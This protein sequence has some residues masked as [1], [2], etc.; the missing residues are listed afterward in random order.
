[1]GAEYFSHSYA[2]ARRHFLDA[3][4]N[5]GGSIRSH[6]VDA[7]ADEDLFID[8][9]TLGPESAPTLLLSSG[10]HGVEGFFGSAVQLALLERLAA[11]GARAG[12]RYV[13]VHAVNPYGFAKIR[14]FDERNVDLNRNFLDGFDAL[15]EPSPLL[16]GLAPLLNPKSGP[17]SDGFKLRMLMRIFRHGREPLKAAIAGGQYHYPRGLFY[18]GEEASVATA[19]VQRECASWIGASDE[20]VHLDFHTGLG[21][22]ATY[23]LLLAD[24]AGESDLDWHR[25]AFGAENVQPFEDP[26]S[27]A[28][29][30]SGLF[31]G[32]MHKRF[33]GIDYRFAAPEFGTYEGVRVLSALRAENRAHHHG[34]ADHPRYRRA[35]KELLECFCPASH[36]WR[37][38]VIADGL[39]I[40][41]QAENA[42]L[43]GAGNA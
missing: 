24:A 2:G 9:A 32:W 36:E 41:E 29:P 27:V 6:R 39:R 28:Y 26:D 8:V 1:M 12:L 34:A 4:A 13:F 37:E 35:K 11:K 38:A 16:D 25:G 23:K 3:A 43:R 15:P 7:E 40:V 42:M 19:I 22:F 21:E 10:V 18:G 30:I 17:R 33:A 20:V 5:V 14:R 31:G